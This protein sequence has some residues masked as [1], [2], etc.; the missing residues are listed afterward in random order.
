MTYKNASNKL[1]EK[2]D[3]YILKKA[4]GTGATESCAPCPVPQVPCPMLR[5]LF[6]VPR[7][8]AVLQGRLSEGQ[9]K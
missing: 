8:P 3:N 5:S 7:A 4:I 6:A 9:E 1:K 2:I